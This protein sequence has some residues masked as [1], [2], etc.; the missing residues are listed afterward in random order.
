MSIE[1]INKIPYRD[2][3]LLITKVCLMFKKIK[4][5]HNI[6]ETKF[7]HSNNLSDS[8]RKQ[9]LLNIKTMSIFETILSL[10]RRDYVQIL[11][12]D[13]IEVDPNPH[14]YLQHWS[15]TTYYKLKHE[16][17]DQFLFMLYA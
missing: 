3:K 2:K 17:I 12:K 7:K 15:K 8:M 1:S 5:A 11:E 16:A 10:L 14:W 9:N 4:N 6:Y 13:F